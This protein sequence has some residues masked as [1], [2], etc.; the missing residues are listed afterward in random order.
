MF[1]TIVAPAVIFEIF[2]N[3]V[4]S[5]TNRRRTLSPVGP[6]EFQ[7]AIFLFHI[8]MAVASMRI[9]LGAITGSPE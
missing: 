9:D 4:V 2:G 1:G 8:H 7:W 3:A 6:A 5:L